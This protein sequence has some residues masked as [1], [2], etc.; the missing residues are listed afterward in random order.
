MAWLNF[1]WVV[2]VFTRL[3]ERVSRVLKADVEP[4]GPIAPLDALDNRLGV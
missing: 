3:A 2:N 1:L 4:L